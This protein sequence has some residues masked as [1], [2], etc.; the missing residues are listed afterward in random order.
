PSVPGG[1]L[2]GVVRAVLT[3]RRRR[4]RQRFRVAGALALA[5]SVLVVALARQL[6]PRPASSPRDSKH[7]VAVRPVLPAELSI[8]D[9][10][11]EA[12][13]AVAGL[14]RQTVGQAVESSRVLLPTMDD[15]LLPPMELPP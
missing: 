11:V 13:S 6:L 14:T 9:T 1:L 4:Q 5:A 10:V 7:S 3:D 15:S 8:R 2:D 12:G